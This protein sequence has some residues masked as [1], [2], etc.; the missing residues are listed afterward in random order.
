M[1]EIFSY[2]D[3][4]LSLDEVTEAQLIAVAQ[5][6]AATVG[7][8]SPEAAKT[9][10]IEAYGPAIRAAVRNFGNG[11]S[12][13][14]SRPFGASYGMGNSEMSL[15]D[16]QSTALVGFLS[17]IE[18]HD[19]EKAP[20]LAGRVAA[21]LARFLSE[22]FASVAAFAVPT[23][24]L[25]RFY[26]ILKAA[27]GDSTAAEGLALE[28]GMS[29]ETFRDVYA[30]VR[31]TGS[32]DRMADEDAQEVAPT[33]VFAPSP[34]V[35]VEDRILVDMAFGAMDDD[36]ARVCELYYGF[37]EYEPVPDAEIAH[38]LDTS[39]PTIQRK[40]IKALG[41]ARKALGVTLAEGV[42]A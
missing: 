9:R 34:V 6:H 35:D 8:P 11:V 2:T 37:T 25:S 13:G 20:R 10:L 15:D 1:L 42:T 39:R 27:E 19:A 38:R 22:E 26:G 5:G 3:A 36:E 7:E 29:R 17:L 23:R 16:L 18:D 4:D 40:R 41:K 32:L 31:G 12:P 24:T 14:D 21:Y 28:Y 33:P 30:A